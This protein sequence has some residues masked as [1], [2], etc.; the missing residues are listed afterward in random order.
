MGGL[1]ITGHEYNPNT[2][3]CDISL[4]FLKEFASVPFYIPWYKSKESKKVFPIML[5]EM[6]DLDPIKR[7]WPA[8]SLIGHNPFFEHTKIKYFVAKEDNKPVG[9]IAVFID[10]NYDKYNNVKTGWI[11][12]FESI[13]KNEV[14]I[15]LINEATS[16]LMDNKY[17]KVIGPAKFN[18]NGEVGLLIDGFD[19]GPY[20]MEPYNPPY[21][22]EFFEDFGFEKVNDWY[23]VVASSESFKEYKNRVERFNEKLKNNKRGKELEKINFRNVEFDNMDEE[24]KKIR[25]VYNDEWGHGHHPQFAPMTE[26]E[27]DKLAVGIKDIALEDLVFMAEKNDEV[28]GV[29][30]SIPNI[31][32]VIA[33]YDSKLKGY[34]P[35]KKIIGFKDIKRDLS[36]YFRIKRRLKKKDFKTARILILGVKDEY[37]KKGIDGMLY[38]K[39]ANALLDM[40]VKEGS[41]SELADINMNIVNPLT[42]MGNIAMTWRVYELK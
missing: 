26:K 14:G 10:Y 33:E 29:A 17:L 40:G 21:Y 18:A 8:N 9:R 3:E 42:K 5:Q 1:R 31:N 37:R 41:G 35:S 27:F 23:S 16:Y 36:I 28:I 32:E 13:E 19:K 38:Y 30:V 4:N 7:N 34:K 24:I 25:K 12:M 22:Q 11:G 20:F 6:G 2:L 39:T 15:S